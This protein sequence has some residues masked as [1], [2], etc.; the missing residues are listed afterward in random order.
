VTSWKVVGSIPNEVSGFL[1]WP[2]PSKLH[3]GPEVNSSSNRNGYQNLP[4]SN[5]RPVYKAE[6]LTTICELLYNMWKT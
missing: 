6:N 2:N 1:N 4:G 5:G 3:C